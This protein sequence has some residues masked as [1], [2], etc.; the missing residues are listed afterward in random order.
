MAD[1]ANNTAPP[2]NAV[3][4]W[5]G[6]LAGP[7][8]W[9]LQMQTGFALVP[10][11]CATGHVFVLHLVTLAGLLIAAAGALVAW[12]DW[13]RFGKEWPKGK[14]G[15]QMRRRFMAVLGLLTSVLFFFVILA[16]GIPSFILN[17]CQ[18]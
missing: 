7:V 18:P 3:A 14:G 17:P 2:A 11:A 8:A 10:W 5:T 15:R 1:V 4:L 9:L 6:I 13:R 12:R 16:Q